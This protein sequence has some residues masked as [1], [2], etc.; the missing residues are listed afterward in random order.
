MKF[1]TQAIHAGQQPDPATGAVMTPIYQT[2]TYKQ[3]SVGKHRGYEYSR[4]GNPTRAAL[5][6]CIAVLEGGQYGLAFASGM[7]ATDTVLRLLAP[8]DHV[9]AGND[10]YG[11]TFR[12]F[13]KEYRR[14][15]LE[16]SY[17]DTTDTAQVEAGLRANTRMVWLETPTNPLLNVSDIQSVAEIVHAHNADTLLVVDNTFATPYLQRPLE[18]GADIVVHSTTKYLGGHS[19]VVGG[20]VVVRH[21][22]IHER[23]AFLQNAA[24]AVPGP[25]DC[26]LVLRGIKTLPVRMDRH[27]QNAAAIAAFLAGHPSVTRVLYPFHA[28]HPQ[29]DVARR[30]MRN[31][32]GMVS[33]IHKGGADAARCL[34][35]QTRIF[36]LAESLGGVES[37]IEVPAAMTHASTAN[38]P[39]AVD[40]GLV[41]L[42][43]GLE[44]EADLIADLERALSYSSNN[45]VKQQTS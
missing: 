12:L 42:S 28:T 40:P 5:E 31:G 1:E 6:A 44:H 27:A 39:L 36:T 26:F 38:S 30:Q 29:V 2:A 16:F 23:L 19:D 24:G 41:R 25:M 8:G 33:F 11:G 34:V 9:L 32:G 20:A 35:E 17:V 45:M 21:A 18:L 13:D 43:V 10:I 22:P 14:Y 37:L 7:A 15:G 4:T 3:D